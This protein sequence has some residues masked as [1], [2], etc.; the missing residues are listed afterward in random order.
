[1]QAQKKMRYGFVAAALAAGLVLSGCS[2]SS[3]EA[4]PTEA[5]SAPAAADG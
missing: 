1:M 5:A 3:E 4:A 2:S